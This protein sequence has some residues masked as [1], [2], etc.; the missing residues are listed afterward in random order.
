MPRDID[1]QM[2]RRNRERSYGEIT[3]DEMRDRDR[4]DSDVNGSDITDPDVGRSGMRR[5]RDER[6]SPRDEDDEDM[7]AG[8]R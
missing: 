1:D 8:Y 5:E 6:R 2:R 3:G 7:Q 4:R